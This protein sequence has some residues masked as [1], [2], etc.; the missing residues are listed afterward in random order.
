MGG[1]RTAASLVAC[2]KDSRGGIESTQKSMVG[3]ES[4]LAS[5]LQQAWLDSQRPK[6][7]RRSSG[8]A[9]ERIG[10]SVT[11]AGINKQSTAD[12]AELDTG[13]QLKIGG[14]HKSNSEYA[15]NEESIL[16][17][18]RR[19]DLPVFPK[20]VVPQL[21]SYSRLSERPRGSPSLDTS[22]TNSSSTSAPVVAAGANIS[23]SGSPLISGACNYNPVRDV[24]GSDDEVDVAR[25]NC[26]DM[27]LSISD[28]GLVDS[29]PEQTANMMMNFLESVLMDE[30]M[31][32]E[33]YMLQGRS[34][35]LAMTKDL[36]QLIHPPAAEAGSSETSTSESSEGIN[37]WD[38]AEI[39]YGES[40]RITNNSHD[41]P[42]FVVRRP[43]VESV[44]DELLRLFA[45]RLGKHVMDE[46][47]GFAGSEA[48]RSV[49]MD[50]AL[51]STSIDCDD[52]LWNSS[53]W[54]SSFRGMPP[55][56]ST[57]SET[58]P[59][60]TSSPPSVDLIDLLLR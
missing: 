53:L 12:S 52:E 23:V 44:E 58:D 21:I 59:T 7:Q 20:K 43:P 39:D 2:E 16:P 33:M 14:I 42:E 24:R 34:A 4:P 46:S 27:E 1:T 13:S 28:G 57:S 10:F 38:E 32:D 40:C 48:G 30:N 8:A 31:E 26:E 5:K 19:A 17:H 47:P 29:P 15:P 54:N 36:A 35:Y 6:F 37:S 60:P 45:C 49:W 51:K 41:A 3:S 55:S 56:V 18:K 22:G 9:G 50:N 11:A 25:K